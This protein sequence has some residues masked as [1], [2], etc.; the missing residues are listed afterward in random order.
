MQNAQCQS[1]I[2]FRHLSTDEGMASNVV[3]QSLMDGDGYMWFATDR[4]LHRYDGYR[5]RIFQHDA[6]DSLSLSGDNVNVLFIDSKQRFWVGTKDAGLNL[7]DKRTGRSRRFYHNPRDSQSIS[8]DS[9][10]SVTEDSKGRIW[11]GTWTGGLNLFDPRTGKCEHFQPPVDTSP[12]AGG[13]PHRSITSVLEDK[14]GRFWVSSWNGLSTFDPGRKQFRFIPNT[15]FSYDYLQDSLISRHIYRV[16]EARNGLIWFATYEG[17]SWYDPATKRLDGC[18][19][20]NVREGHPLLNPICTIIDGPDGLMWC[21]SEEGGGIL[22]FD[23][24]T[25]R[26]TRIV[27]DANIPYSLS[28]NRVRELYRDR[29]G[30]YWIATLGGGVDFYNPHALSF[31]TY[32]PDLKHFKREMIRAM[33]LDSRGI[34]W[35]AY[36]MGFGTFDLEAKFF[37][38]HPHSDKIR[39]F[40][41]HP[42]VVRLIED[43]N[44]VLWIG[45]AD[46][47]VAA[48]DL[49]TGLYHYDPVRMSDTWATDMEEDKE[50]RLWVFTNYYTSVRRLQPDGGA[51]KVYLDRGYT[52]ERGSL[53]RDKRGTLWMRA[54]GGLFK[55]D[56][57]RDRFTYVIGDSINNRN[58]RDIIY[59][60]CKFRHW[61]VNNKGIFRFDPA[62]GKLDLRVSN[63]RMRNARAFGDVLE[64]PQGLLWITSDLGLL[65]Y[66]PE[67]DEVHSYTHAD[68]LP[69]RDLSEAKMIRVPDGHMM[70]GSNAGLTEFRPHRSG[71]SPSSRMVISA[72]F[73]TGR[74]VAIDSLFSSGT[75]PILEPDENALTL[76]FALLDHRTPWNTWYE[77]HLDG[78][79]E[80]WI[81]AGERTAA[82][83][84]HLPPGKYT[85][86]VRGV[87]G[88]EGVHAETSL[89]FSILPPWYRTWWAYLLFVLIPVL[90][91]YGIWRQRLRQLQ[92][93]HDLEIHTLHESQLEQLDAM[94]SSFFS[95]I[96]HEFRTPLTLIQAPVEQLLAR[97]SDDYTRRKLRLVQR[98][99][100]R[101]LQLINQILDLSKIDA[102]KFRIR[103]AEGDIVAFLRGFVAVFQSAAE[104]RQIS[105]TIVTED[106]KRI[107][108]FDHEVLEKI[109]GNLLTNALKYTPS[110]GAITVCVDN[111]SGRA[112]HLAEA[113]AITVEDTGPGIA[114]EH[115]EHIFDRFFR[116]AEHEQNRLGSGIGLALVQELTALHHGEVRVESRVGEGSRFVVVLPTNA[117][118]FNEEEFGT[119]EESRSSFVHPDHEVEESCESKRPAASDT[120]LPLVLLVEDNSEI[121]GLLAEHLQSQYRICEA[122]DGQEGLDT[123][124]HEVPDIIISDVMMPRMD[125]NTMCQRLKQ[126]QAT[127]H[128]PI[129]LLTARASG[130]SRLEGLEARADAYLVKPVD[131]RELMIRVRN[132]V[133][134]RERMKQKFTLKGG[135]LQLAKKERLS[136]EEVFLLKAVA[137]VETHLDDDNF[138][139]DQLSAEMGLSRAQLH[140]KLTALTDHSTSSFIR[141]IRLQHGREM[142]EARAGNVAEIAYAVG[143]KTQAHFSRCFREEFG[144]SPSE[145]IGK[146][147]PAG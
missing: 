120:T 14:S 70:I 146:S 24:K 42:L 69:V 8:S 28:D 57:T 82:N 32:K 40:R 51:P 100:G 43:H 122:G 27:H 136:T 87:N 63:A 39:S 53:Y 12:P 105:L 108:L 125:G 138:S 113:I 110:G 34:L 18:R 134:L 83:Y 52:M 147:Q 98:S 71:P 2:R 30:C 48:V 112:P 54:W 142:L 15:V 104:R 11:V 4:G 137:A 45:S 29:L 141:S 65:S 117:S 99:A 116:L 127:S 62:V 114:A 17:I 61:I 33:L 44:N 88:N 10:T 68:G 144:C 135:F 13:A 129:I 93:H 67:H 106:P 92:L 56:E 75:H 72:M 95:S 60:D 41:K 46:A 74:R 124:V 47:N 102:Q 123:A 38:K 78:Y 94:K 37:T 58:S 139:V 115:I 79:D 26:Y 111:G 1:E 96:S 103:V 16:S 3:Y 101:L 86:R 23:P 64:G 89:V 5:F 7:F 145:V 22:R 19:M 131:M 73:A 20:D 97:N 50:G 81:E 77:Y 128:I 49:R 6:R 133:E 132:L 107:G 21:G 109:L 59:Q 31:T 55:F 84:S 85:F 119:S 126:H 118:V 143:F 90:A 80:D 130:G 9:I 36:H 76:Q 91:V 140:R 121:R 66:D 35:V 25:K